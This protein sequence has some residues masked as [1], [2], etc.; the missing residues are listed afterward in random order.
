MLSSCIPIFFTQENCSPYLKIRWMLYPDCRV[1]LEALPLLSC[2][3]LKRVVFCST[4]DAI[5]RLINTTIIKKTFLT[6]WSKKF[7]TT[8]FNTLLKTDNLPWLDLIILVFKI[9]LVASEINRKQTI[10]QWVLSSNF[11]CLRVHVH[12]SLIHI[13]LVIWL[14]FVYII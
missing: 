6:K 4:Y 8:W 14:W 2:F 13:C 9:D 11:Y 5:L 12:L 3:I 1:L 10:S 7:P